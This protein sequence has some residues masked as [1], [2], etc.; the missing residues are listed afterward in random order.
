[1]Y[2]LLISVVTMALLFGAA[3]EETQQK[4]AVKSNNTGEAHK[5][6]GCRNENV[7][8]PCKFTAAMRQNEDPATAVAGTAVYR[9]DFLITTAEREIVVTLGY[10]RVPESKGNELIK[11]Y[12]KN[13][14][15][16]CE[17]HIVWP[18]CNPQG[19]TVGINVEPPSFATPMRF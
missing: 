12:E 9:I 13:S 5:P 7:K 18:P 2:K 10:F 6:G 4:P 14:P 1:M 15:A 19:T 3:C 8:G 11:Y 17:A 16:K